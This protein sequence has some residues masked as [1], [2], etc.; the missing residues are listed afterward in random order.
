MAALP[1][2][3]FRHFCCRKVLSSSHNRKP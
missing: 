1:I 2:H 3:F